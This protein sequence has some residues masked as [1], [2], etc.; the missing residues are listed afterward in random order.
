MKD[1][2]E[3]PVS[4]LSPVNSSSYHVLYGSKDTE[5]DVKCLYNAG[6]LQPGVY[7]LRMHGLSSLC[8]NYMGLLVVT[9]P[10]GIV[11]MENASGQQEGAN[12]VFDLQGRP[13]SSPQRGIYIRNGK[14]VVYSR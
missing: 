3:L 13:V 10:T 14:K 9:D 7:L 6:R 8:D 12:V 1:G 2:A 11:E 5:F 4:S